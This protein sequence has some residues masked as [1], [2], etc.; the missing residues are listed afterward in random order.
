MAAAQESPPM[1][2]WYLL[3]GLTAFAVIASNI[4]FQWTP[5]GHL[6]AAIGALAAFVVTVMIGSAADLISLL[7]LRLRGRGLCQLDVLRDDPGGQDLRLSGAR[8]RARELRQQSSG[9][10]IG[11]DLRQFG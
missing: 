11:D 8:R 1:W 6:A 5:N 3:Q 9:A 7:R 10:R 2:K 4:H